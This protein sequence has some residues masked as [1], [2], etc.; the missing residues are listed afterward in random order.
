MSRREEVK[1]PKIKK[2]NLSKLTDISKKMTSPSAFSTYAI[3]GV[4]VTTVLTIVSTRKQCKIENEKKSQV[5]ILENEL[6]RED[7]IQEVKETAKIYAPVIVSAAATIFCMKKSDQKWRAWNGLLNA[8]YRAAQERTAHYRLL[9]PAAVGAELVQGFNGREHTDGASWFCIKDFPFEYYCDEEGNLKFEYKDIWFESTVEDVIE[10]EYKL[11]RNFII[12][13]C[14]STREFFAFLGIL[15][16]HPAIW[17]DTLGWDTWTFY[18]DGMQP[19]ID[20]EHYSVQEPSTKKWINE[21]RFTWDPW[22]SDDGS[23]LAWGY[24]EGYGEPGSVLLHY[25]SGPKEDCPPFSPPYAF[26]PNN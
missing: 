19:W 15:D 23:P 17:G 20:F 7:V 13:E 5:D 18:D 21:I 24:G 10:A 6:T 26:I 25:D 11:N 8:S 12:R 3:I 22:L 4:V 14:A 9:A 2:P 16:M 1:T